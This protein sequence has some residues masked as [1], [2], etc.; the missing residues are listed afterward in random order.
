MDWKLPLIYSKQ[1]KAYKAI[2]EVAKGRGENITFDDF[3]TI[4]KFSSEYDETGRHMSNKQV[5]FYL[6][7]EG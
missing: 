1:K 5:Y 6:D 2:E 7:K 3:K 4:T